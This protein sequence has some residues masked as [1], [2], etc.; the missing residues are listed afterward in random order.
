MEKVIHQDKLELHTVSK[1]RAA[2][3]SSSCT[4]K[5]ITQKSRTTAPRSAKSGL[6]YDDQAAM[7]PN[8]CFLIN[9]TMRIAPV[10]AF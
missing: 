2:G 6:P 4:S 8:Y 1:S 9:V 3:I 10:T 7:F 5:T